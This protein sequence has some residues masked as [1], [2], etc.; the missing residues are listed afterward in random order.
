MKKK[1]TFIAIITLLTFLTAC[2]VNDSYYEDYTPPAPPSGIQVLNGDGR[3]DISWNHNRENDVAGYNVYYSYSYNGRYTL[4]GSTANNYFIDFGANNGELYY[5]AVTAY[6][7]N[8]NESDLSYDVVYAVPRPEGFNQAIFDYRRFPNNAGYSFAN[9]SV[10]RY[11]DQN[12]DV[13]FE[14]YQGTYYLVVWDDTDIQDMGP[15]NDI[16]DIP[17][18]PTAGWSPSKDVIARTGHTYVIWTWNN[19]FAKIRI[20]SIT[21][22]RIVFDWAYQLVEGEPML[23]PSFKGGIRKEILKSSLERE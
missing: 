17:F 13:F 14:N 3:V 21:P 19:H 2:N 12:S 4:I 1:L 8:G 23:K 18:A 10:V 15:T 22:D 16:Y 9:Y 11:D 7:Y 6:D 20:K 5:Y